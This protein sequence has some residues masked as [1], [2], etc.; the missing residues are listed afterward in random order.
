MRPNLG[1]LSILSK[2]QSKQ[3][4]IQKSNHLEEASNKRWAFQV[5][6]VV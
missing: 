4:K 5:A 1:C 2:I 6:K 3:Q